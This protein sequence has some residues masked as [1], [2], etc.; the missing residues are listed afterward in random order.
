[1]KTKAK[2]IVAIVVSIAL[3]IGSS[4]AAAYIMH[5]NE[6]IETSTT[7]KNG[8]SAY[9][10]AVQNGYSGT[11][12]DWIASLS[13]KSAFEIAKQNGYQGT[14]KDWSARLNQLAESKT[15]GILTAKLNS[16]NE[17][18]LT[19]SD[20]TRLNL[21]KANLKGDTVTVTASQITT[22]VKGADGKNG[23]DGKNGIDGKDGVNGKDGTNGKDGVNGTD[24]KD[25]TDGV[26]I[27][28]AAVN[29]NG[30]LELTFSNYQTV[31]VGKVVG[32]TGLKGENGLSAYQ[33]AVISGA[34]TAATE[35]EWIASLKGA[36]G[37]KGETG[38]AGAQGPQG[39]K[40]V[41]GEKGETGAQGP[42]GEKGETGATGAAGANGK[43]A[44]EIAKENGVT[45]SEG[46]WLNSLK[47][48]TGAAGAAGKSAFEIA[49]EAGLTA[50]TSEIAWIMSLKGETGATGP[51]GEKGETGATGAAGENG[52]SA[53]EIA[54]A[55][56][57]IP[58]SAT[59]AEW[60]NSLK[61]APGQN[62]LTPTIGSN[63]NWFIG[64]TDTGVKASGTNGQ[65]GAD[66]QTPTIGANGNWWIGGVDTGVAAQGP[67]GEKG[68]TGATGAQG[69]KGETGA[70]GAQ[71]ENGLTPTIGSNGNWFIGSTDTGVQAK[72]TNGATPTVGNNGNWFINGTDTGIKAT[73]TGIKAIQLNG[74]DMDITLTDNSVVHLANVK[75]EDGANGITPT[76]GT[77][78]NWYLGTVDT[79]VAAQGPQGEKGE[80]GA[81]GAQGEKGETGAAG[82]NGK[83][84]N[85][86]ANGNW[87]IDGVDTG[88]AAQGPQG[89]KGETGATGAQ[90][91][92][93]EKGETGATGAQG[94]QGEKGDTGATGAQGAHGEN[95]LTP[96]IGSNGNWF[97]G[98][99]DTGVKAS[100]TNGQNGADGQTPTIGANGNWW[101]G[102]V[103]TGVAA[104]GQT[105]TG[106]TGATVDENYFTLLL[107]NGQTIQLNAANFKGAQGEKGEQGETGAQ[108][109]SVLSLSIDS[110]GNLVATYSNNPNSPQTVAT[111]AQI[112]G[113][114][115]A[116]GPQGETG[117]TGAQGPQGEKGETGRGIE[118]VALNSENELIIKYTDGST[119]NLGKLFNNNYVTTD[120][121]NFTY[122]LLETGTYEITG[123]SA[124]GKE[125]SELKIPEKID[126]IKVTSIGKS[127]FFGCDNLKTV[128]I[129]NSVRTIKSGAFANC[130]S[131][132]LTIPDSVVEID[133]A[134]IGMKKGSVNFGDKS[135]WLVKE[136][137][138]SS[139]EYEDYPSGME[140]WKTNEYVSNYE[141]NIVLSDISNNDDLLY[142]SLDLYDC[143]FG[144]YTVSGTKKRIT[145]SFP[146]LVRR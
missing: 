129:P 131:L 141:V 68:E 32:A 37:E 119:Q 86:G 40:G 108:G 1:M 83:T 101:I 12:Q 17:L 82:E 20:G 70:A 11:L 61:G 93:G 47:G 104:K 22:V 69:E 25:G 58:D 29:N 134:F 79:G 3:I 94:P 95:G 77:N 6:S 4:F 132:T 103:D 65:N 26:G 98:S 23:V 41:Q 16:V 14:E 102:T 46:D 130:K 53:F 111:A 87:W 125:L 138:I 18:V 66:G 51:Q 139:M 144:P 30:E 73:G 97:I 45:L 13:G 27:K 127:A 33:I 136:C 128:N 60:L 115:G 113:E 112:K 2:K 7:V 31:N 43:S 57:Y 114:T 15:L 92:Q 80:T 62:G 145:L 54:K 55:N 35:Q 133:E 117:A 64:S 44:Y 96:T 19:L 146:M 50:E 107:S 106:I 75:G 59:E 99:T 110:N 143:T 137:R 34:T 81:A 8:L 39:E 5:R 38:A 10:L 123:L 140:G 85:I 52:K 100:G 89:E 76:I 63:G 135:K 42:Q 21:G 91:P 109:V 48:E 56:G 71:G 126:G 36:Q 28:S 105:G 78:G 72:G 118:S 142:D 122:K 116:Q 84:P 74:K 9:E 121:L 120:Q 67:Q 24:G 90:G 88:V 49:R 124:L